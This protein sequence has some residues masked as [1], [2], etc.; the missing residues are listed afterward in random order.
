MATTKSPPYIMVCHDTEEKICHHS[1]F[2]MTLMAMQIGFGVKYDSNLTVLWDSQYI[3][4]TETTAESVYTFKLMLFIWC[5]YGHELREERE[6]LELTW[7]RD[8]W[9]DDFPSGSSMPAG[10]LE[11]VSSGPRRSEVSWPTVS[12][13]ASKHTCSSRGRRAPIPPTELRTSYKII[14]HN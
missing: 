4:F 12:P 6:G 5:I 1:F 8:Y 11:D 3:Q 13:W 9:P 2:I 7:L 10:P 14:K